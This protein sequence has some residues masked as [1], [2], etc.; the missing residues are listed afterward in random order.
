MHS[1]AF[2]AIERLRWVDESTLAYD[3]TVDDPKIFT[4]PF[5]ETL[6]MTLRPDWEQVGLYEFF[7]Q[8]NNRCPGGDCGQ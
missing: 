7:C 4:E 8:E 2:S 1:D 3:L 5:T 6:Q